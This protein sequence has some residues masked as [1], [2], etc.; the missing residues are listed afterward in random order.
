MR[1][2]KIACGKF[3]KRL[4]ATRERL[5]KLVDKRRNVLSRVEIQDLSERAVAPSDIK[6]TSSESQ[7]T[8]AP[9]SSPHRTRAAHALCQVLD[10]TATLFTGSRLRLHFAIR[11]PPCVGLGFRG[12]PPHRSTAS[13]AAPAP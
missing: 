5:S 7:I 3:G 2:F 13:A 4:R 1:G 10:Q 8:L 9:L 12:A 11:P 6:V